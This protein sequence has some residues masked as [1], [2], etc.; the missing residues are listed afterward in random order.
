MPGIAESTGHSER[1][2]CE[3][4]RRVVLPGIAAMLTVYLVQIAVGLPIHVPLRVPQLFVHW[5]LMVSFA[6]AGTVVALYGTLVS[7]TPRQQYLAILFPV[8]FE[9][10][11][12]VWLLRF[13]MAP[14]VD[15]AHAPYRFMSPPAEA[16]V[17]YWFIH[18][19]IPAAFGLR[20]L[21]FFSDRG[22]NAAVA[23]WPEVPAD[24][25]LLPL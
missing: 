7:S 12:W 21:R 2:P 25:Y 22:H 23:A 1:L 24:L 9:I 16:S 14:W 10:L 6:V 11:K 18:I 17:R 20:R 4:T 5:D 8:V 13:P 15:P 3:T 19:L